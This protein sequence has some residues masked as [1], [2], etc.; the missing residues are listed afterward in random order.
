MAGSCCDALSA[1]R[2]LRAKDRRV[3]AFVQ[4]LLARGD[5]RLGQ[6]L[7]S[8]YGDPSFRAWQ[9]AAKGVGIDL[10]RELYTPRPLSESHFPWLHLAPAGSLERLEREESLYRR[11]VEALKAE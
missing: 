11:S 9:Q 5:R 3:S 10:E 6:V 2:R 4:A 7:A 1:G 8:I